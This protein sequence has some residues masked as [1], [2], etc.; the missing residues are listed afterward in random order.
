[1]STDGRLRFNTVV[2]ATDLT[3]SGSHALRYAARIAHLHQA[4]LVVVHA[5]DPASYAFPEGMP[6]SLASDRNALEA[7]G[8][9]ENEVR[10]QGI[11]VHSVVETGVIYERILRTALDHHADLIVLGTKAGAKVGR[12]A[13][14]TVARHLL[15][16]AHCPILTV[17]PAADVGVEDAGH[18][19]NVLVATDFS[20]ASLAALNYAQQLVRGQLVVVH[21]NA[22]SSSKN[23]ARRLELLR[24]LAP[25]DAAH[26]A[27]VEH[28]IATS[29][30]GHAIVKEAERLN[31]DLVILGSPTA[32][33]SDEDLPTSTV[34]QVVSNASCPV[35]CVPSARDAVVEEVV[36]EFAL[37]Q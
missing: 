15:A 26:T 17:P 24:Y 22:D 21:A 13:L 3:D 12:A 11:Q 14:G 7:L 18:W 27:P 31:A 30:P 20:T 36:R 23:R 37:S 33:L 32:K 6:E 5:I 10:A 2:V 1:M 9:I 34:L 35:L 8:E 25:F 28:I 29:E 19:R 16:S 4:R